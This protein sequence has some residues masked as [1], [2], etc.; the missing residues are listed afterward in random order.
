MRKEIND[1]LFTFTPDITDDLLV[2]LK[3][4]KKLKELK[5]KYNNNKNPKL[6]ININK[7]QE[8]VIK[9]MTDIGRKYPNCGYGPSFYRW[10]MSEEHKPY[11]SF[12]N[13]SAMRLV[14]WV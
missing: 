13:G 2:L 7:L 6:F 3:D 11:N 8:Q 5:N 14:P 1:I 4:I 10:I 9:S 12:G